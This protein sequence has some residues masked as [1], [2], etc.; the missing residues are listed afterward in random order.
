MVIVRT[1]LRLPI[2]GGG[3]DLPSFYEN[4]GS[5]FVSAAINRYIYITSHRSE[6]D[7]RIRCRYSVMEEVDNV[8]DIKN[9]ILRETLKRHGIGDRIEITSHA[10]IPSGMGLGSSGSFGVGVCQAIKEGGGKKELAEE[11]TDIQLKLGFP[12]GKQDQYVAA[13]GGVNVY[14]ISKKGETEVRDLNTDFNALKQ[15]LVLF[16]TGIRRDANEV[17][18][19]Q[20]EKGNDP[21]MVVALKETQAIGIEQ[22]DALEDYNFDM[23]GKLLNAHWEIKQKRSPIMTNKEIDGWYKLG[24]K[25]GAIGGKLVGAGGG[26]FLMFYTS[27][28]EKLIKAMPLKH[29]DFDW[30]FQG[31]KILI[32]D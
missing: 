31:S 16:C 4:F 3:T 17:L 7:S 30:D 19:T 25:N 14:T 12:I 9:E 6:F 15:R 20:K 10:E 28:P 27:D 18:I 5:V 23:Y 32:N 8:E 13:F 1:P 22:L 29:M 26:G 24:L 21:S 11:A 2:C